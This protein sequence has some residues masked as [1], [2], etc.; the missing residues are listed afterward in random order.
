MAA[1]PPLG[2]DRLQPHRFAYMPLWQIVE[3]IR[4]EARRLSMLLAL[5]ATQR[6]PS[7]DRVSTFTTRLNS[8]Y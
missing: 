7:S 8:A 3:G 5:A 1:R 6:R 4:G 2:Y